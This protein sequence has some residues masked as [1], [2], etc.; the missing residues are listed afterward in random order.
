MVL[1]LGAKESAPVVAA[2][3]GVAWALTGARW[4]GVALAAA[5]VALFFVDL[6]GV[7]DGRPRRRL[8]A[9]GEAGRRKEIAATRSSGRR[10][11]PAHPSP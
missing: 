1:A 10:L 2:G 9:L 7:T 11:S 5:G 3:I 6:D 4:Q 8:Q